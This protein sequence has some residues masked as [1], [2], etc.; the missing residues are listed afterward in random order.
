LYAVYQ[1]VP[2]PMTLNEPYPCFQSHHSLMLNIS[3]T[4]TDLAIITIEGE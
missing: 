4:A 3:Q 1:M 2:F